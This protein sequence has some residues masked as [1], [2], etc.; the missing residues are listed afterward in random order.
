MGIILT[1]HKLQEAKVAKRTHWDDIA[2]EEVDL[3]IE[4]FSA[5]SPIRP[6]DI[7]DLTY[8]SALSTMG[9][10]LTYMFILFQ[11]KLETRNLVAKMNIFS[12][13]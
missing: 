13:H 3:L 10:I 12:P 9:I 5:V 2:L 7:F 11:L 6:C 8:S 4:R 1:M